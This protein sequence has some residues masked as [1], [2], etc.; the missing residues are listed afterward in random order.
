MTPIEKVRN[1]TKQELINLDY[2]ELIELVKS[3]TFEE[4]LELSAKIGYPV[5]LRLCMGELK[6]DFVMLQDGAAAIIINSKGQILLQSRADRDKWGVPGGCQEAGERFEEV[7][8]REIKEETNLDVLEEDLELLSVVSGFSRKNSYP[9]GDTVFNNTIL[10]LVK[11]FSGELRWDEESK[12][13]AFFDIDKLPENQ[14]DPDLIDIYKR[15][16]KK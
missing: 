16:L 3:L 10:Y 4:K 11:K 1:L 12:E 6:H 8:I 7:V 14:N 15:T 5:F 9:N 13:M 2:N